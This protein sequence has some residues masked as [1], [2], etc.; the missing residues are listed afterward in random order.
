[1]LAKQQ[2][3]ASHSA[4][5]RSKKRIP[6]RSRLLPYRLHRRRGPSLVRHTGNSHPSLAV[7]MSSPA[8]D[9]QI[10]ALDDK[11]LNYPQSTSAE[12]GASPDMKRFLYA[13]QQLAEQGKARTRAWPKNKSTCVSHHQLLEFR[14]TSHQP[15]RYLPC[16]GAHS[17]RRR[18]L[19]LGRK[20]RRST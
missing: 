7:K 14:R 1:M 5:S 9:E 20:S 12:A 3:R 16:A 19:N 15:T 13:Q 4:N 11:L 6:L 17:C 2:K 10:I 18:W 8:T